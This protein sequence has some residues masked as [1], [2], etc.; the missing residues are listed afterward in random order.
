M[1]KIGSR[2]IAVACAEDG[3][4]KTF[5]EGTYAGDFIP[6]EEVAG[7]MGEALREH[8]VPNP[9][10][11][12]DNGKVV[13]GCECWWGDVEAFKKRI[14]DDYEWIIIDPEDYRKNV[15]NGIKE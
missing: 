3:K 1:T 10:I 8:G 4:V 2:V 5:G 12:L 14:P 15:L 7:W 13:W 9:R 6:G 11:D